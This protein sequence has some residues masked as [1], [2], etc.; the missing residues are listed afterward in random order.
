VSQINRPPE[1]PRAALLS[2]PA[3]WR[4]EN[5]AFVPEIMAIPAAIA[6]YIVPAAF[7]LT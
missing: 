4:G 3:A 5:V 2:Y 1:I 7:P 6:K